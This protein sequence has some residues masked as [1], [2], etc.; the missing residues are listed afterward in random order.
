[1]TLSAGTKLGPYEIQ[2]PLG[3]GGMGEVYRARDTRLSREVAVKVLPS[4]RAPTPEARERFEREARTI[5]QLSHPH[6]CVLHDVGREGETEY[7]VMELLE[8]ETL[9]DRLGRGPLPLEQALRFGA[10]IASALAAAH[11][12]GIVHRDL[13]P[14]N[15]M[16]TRSG[17][18]LLDFGLARAFAAPAEVSGLTEAPTMARDLTAEGSIVGTVAYMAPEQLEGRKTDART[19]IFAFGAVL[20][21]MLTGRKAFSA[22]SQAALISAILTTEPPAVSSVQPI[23]PPELDRLVRTCLSKDPAERW[24][25]AHDVELQLRS[26]GGSGSVSRGEIPAAPG[27]RRRPVLPW[28]IAAAAVLVAAAALLRGGR[29]RAAPAGTV[30]FA[31]PPPD[32]GAFNYVV[33]GNF[34]VVSPDGSQLAYVAWAGKDIATRVWL[35]PLSAA[36]ARPIPGTERAT[37]LMWSPDGR[38]IGFFTRDKLKR[39]DLAGGAPVPI[40]DI[41]SGGGKAGS[42]GRNEI[43]FT[44][45]QG[46]ALYR[47]PVSGGVP[48]VLI[49]AD[50]ERK[51]LRLGWPWFLPDGERFLYLERD[52]DGHGNLMLVEPGKPPRVVTHISSFFQY[53]DPGFLVYSREGTLVA[54]RFDEKSG[55]LSG[56]PFSVADRVRYFFSTASAAFAARAGTI[57]YLSQPDAS[58]LAW[59][60]RSGRETA[61]LGASGNYL[62]VYLTADGRRLL[63]DRTRPGLETYHVWSYDLERGIESPVTNGIDTE[64]FPRLLADGKTL[65]FSAVRG[66]PPLLRRRDLATGKE[67]AL[68][69]GRRAF[70]KPEDV[71]P[72]GR[73]LVFVERTET[74]NFDI[75]SLDLEKAAQPA[76][77]LQSSFDKQAVR[78]SPDGRFIA[79]I[80]NE[81]GRN[82]VYVTP[83]PGPGE[84]VRVSDG[85][86]GALRWGRD[87][88]LYYLAGDGRLMTVPVRTTPELRIGAPTALF[89]VTGRPWI[90]FDLTPDGQRILAIVPEVDGNESPLN[91]VLNWSA[92][93]AKP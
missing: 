70:Q 41:P 17:V 81:S 44:S 25:S 92:E 38:S 28:A 56:D 82:E 93:A 78:F 77:V 59:Y 8:G 12:R 85:G 68:T 2:A 40:C 42:W 21:E 51:D 87:G 14:G 36:A 80:S 45:I 31:I 16:L 83:F 35:R 67:T 32:G 62:D 53:L 91:V 33:E 6:I 49:R 24:Q 11:A 18:K 30:R 75:W 26:I 15:V 57:A 7:L 22:G 5:S 19:D 10:D 69:E 71:S 79:F 64:A 34:M 60:D 50:K 84:R 20:Y 9:T 90:D 89:T 13:K 47:V 66:T 3:K 27:R 74:G 23:T 37:S 61:K 72:D 65:I 29:P 4:Q 58:R 76:P 52:F 88:A 1:M 43:L 39:V 73:T 55:R 48:V 54:Q 46:G 86:A 63:F